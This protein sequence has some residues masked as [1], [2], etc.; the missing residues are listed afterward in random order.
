MVLSSFVLSGM[1]TGGLLLTLGMVTSARAAGEPDTI[2]LWPNGAPGALGTQPEDNPTLT[3]YRPET[4]NGAAMV[5][6]PGGGYGVLAPHEGEPVARWLT[7]LGVTAGVLKYRLGPR[8]HHPIELGDASR[9]LRLMRNRAAGWG[10]DPHRIGILGFSAGGHLASTLLT[11][12]DSGD[13]AAPDPIDRLS[14]R[15]DLGVLIYPV[16]TL[17]DPYTHGGSREN[18]LGPHPSPE[19]I[20]RLSNEKHVTDQTPPTFLI[21]TSEDQAVPAENSM[22]FAMALHRAHVPFE[23]HIFEKG[24][25]GFGL[26]GHDPVLSTWPAMCAAWM[27]GRGFL[28]HGEAAR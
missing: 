24:P 5:V 21:S 25:H 10:V 15:P 23:L 26:G 6:C 13:A 19:L 8:Y 11:H 12:F 1:L 22:L 28:T 4:P 18:L 16:I 3:I 17:T 20:D 14:S 7:T 2:V 9:A 27:N